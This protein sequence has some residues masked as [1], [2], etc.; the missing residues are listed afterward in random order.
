MDLAGR[1]GH[2]MTVMTAVDHCARIARNGLGTQ[3]RASVLDG[4]VP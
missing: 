4:A 2:L 3:F 1:W